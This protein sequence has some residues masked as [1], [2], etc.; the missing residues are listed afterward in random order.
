MF[1]KVLI[2]NRGEIALRVIRACRELG[3]ATVAIYSEADRDCLHV[4]FADEAVCVGA[5]PS[6]ESYRHRA[7]II[8]AALIT[9]ADGIHPGYGFLAENADFA[10]ECAAT[11]LKFIGPSPEVIR[12][13][14]DKAMA[15]ALMQEHQVPVIPG[16]E[17][18]I[19]TEQDALR[20]ADL[21]GYPVIVKAAAG[22]GG[23]GM[24]I[25]E[26]EAELLPSVKLAQS[27]AATAF[28][29]PGVYLEKYIEEPRHIEVQIL[30]DEHGR[31]LHLGE[32]D[33]SLQT[34]RHQK[35]LEEAPGASLS[36]ELRAAITGAAVRAAQLVGYQN[37][38]TIEFLADRH[39]RFYFLEMNTRIQVEHPVTEM[40]TGIDI[41][42]EQIHIAAGEPLRLTQE[43]V[44]F[45][46]HAIE[47][48]I[49]AEDPAN[50]LTPSAG[51]LTR[52][53]LP[54]GFGVRVD[55]HIYEGYNVPPFYDSLLCKLVAWGAD[56]GEAIARMARALHEMD[57]QG[58]PTTLPFHRQ[59]MRDPVYRGGEVTTS[60]IRRRTQNGHH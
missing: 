6:A 33:C 56:R 57:L 25:V 40:I 21:V 15:R 47:C 23:K 2:A 9:H 29:N 20:G 17:E 8:S 55:T 53:L 44:R 50:K 41:V 48:R 3:I 14:G 16:S 36:A 19:Q 7:N 54:G 30:A 11:G 37:A 38:G 31:V 28:G 51:R 1:Q 46:G 60:F 22:G 42:A 39:G 26:T 18:V 10:E 4:R 45:S 13:M 34:E 32:R 49:T 27:E 59:V 5:A 12:A 35:M 24:R 43:Q 52:V 58:V